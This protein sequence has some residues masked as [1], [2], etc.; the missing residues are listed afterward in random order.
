VVNA[1]GGTTWVRGN[2][3]FTLEPDGRVV[4]N[5]GPKGRWRLAATKQFILKWDGGED[6]EWTF[7]RGM[8][9]LSRPGH[10]F[11]RQE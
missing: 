6:E 11:V 1:I 7:D 2:Q 9:V 8:K 5:W 10:K 4:A 3:S